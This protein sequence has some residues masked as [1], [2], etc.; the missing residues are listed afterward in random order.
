MQKHKKPSPCQTEPVPDG[1]KINLPVA[2]SKPTS[3]MVTYSRRLKK[4]LQQLCEESI[5]QMPGTNSKQCSGARA[6]SPAAC[7]LDHGE[8]AVPQKPVSKWIFPEQ[9]CRARRIHAEP[10]SCQDLWLMGGPYLSGLF[11]KDC[12][13][14]EG[15]ILE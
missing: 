4:V 7:G 15:S 13:L 9:S 2:N 6:D 11:L 10:D 12:I 1:C 5:L 8:A 14:R 3:N